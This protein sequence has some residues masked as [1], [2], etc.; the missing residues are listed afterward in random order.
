MVLNPASTEL[1]DSVVVNATADQK[2]LMESYIN[3]HFNNITS[4]NGN[5]PN[6]KK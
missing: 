4:L 1:F 2:E 3:A 6:V 5:L